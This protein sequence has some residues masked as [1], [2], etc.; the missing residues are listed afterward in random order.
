MHNNTNFQVF[1]LA[2]SFPFFFLVPCS[3]WAIICVC[4]WALKELETHEEGKKK[5]S[6]EE[7]IRRIII[8][9]RHLRRDSRRKEEEEEEEEEAH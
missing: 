3:I 9:R 4:I 5:R 2:F 6:M 8:R 1:S 7:R